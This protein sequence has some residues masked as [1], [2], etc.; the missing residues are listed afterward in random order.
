MIAAILKRIARP[1]W[2]TITDD[3]DREELA[4]RIFGVNFGYY[5]HPDPFVWTQPGWRPIRKREYG[6]AIRPTDEYREISYT[7]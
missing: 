3:E 4:F 6:E 1:Q 7:R 2:V 5:K